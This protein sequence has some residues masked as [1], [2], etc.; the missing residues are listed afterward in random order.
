MNKNEKASNFSQL[1]F[2]SEVSIIFQVVFIFIRYVNHYSI[3]L[4][5]IYLFFLVFSG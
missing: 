4:F 3:S 2:T 1:A 5:Q